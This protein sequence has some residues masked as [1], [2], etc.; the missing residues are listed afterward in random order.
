MASG[1]VNHVCRSCHALLTQANDHMHKLKFKTVPEIQKLVADGNVEGL[2]SISQTYLINAFHK[3]RFNM[4]NRRGIHGACPTDMLHSL[5]LGIFK[6]LRDIFFNQ[7]GKTSSI[8]KDVNGLAKVFCRLL[9]RQSDRS[10]PKCSFSQGIQAGRLMGREYRG[11]LLIMLC[12]L[13]STS[14]R[15]IM[16]Q[17]RKKMLNDDVKVDDWIMLVETLLQW[18][19]YLCSDELLVRDVRRL[20]KKHRY[21]MYLMRRIAHRTEG[22]GLKIMKFHTVLHLF[23]D[24]MVNGCPLEFDTSANEGHHKVS[25]H[26]AR[27]T[28]KAAKT[29]NLQ[30][31]NRITEFRLIEY[32]LL[33]LEEDKVPWNYFAGCRE[34]AS[35]ATNVSTSMDEDSSGEVSMA[36]ST[37]SKKEVQVPDPEDE[38]QAPEADVPDDESLEV[39]TGDAQLEVFEDEDGTRCFE[40]RTRSKYKDRTRLNLDIIDFLYDL[41]VLLSD[42]LGGDPLP[43]FTHHRRGDHIFRA[44]PNYRG[45]GA[46]RDWVW[47]DWGRNYGQ[48]PC[49]IWC[50]VKLECLGNERKAPQHG[51]ITLNQNGVYAVVESSEMEPDDDEVGRSAIMLP[52]RKTIVLTPDGAVAKRHFYLADVN[53]FVEPCSVV[54]DIGGPPNRY[55]VVKPR[56]K[57]SIDFLS[58]VRDSHDLDEMDDLDEDDQ[59]IPDEKV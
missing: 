28:Q 11:V 33:E 53:A 24:I 44:H 21:I 18:E 3:L 38:A 52:I 35:P 25:K 13:R 5:Q 45:K 32:A 58:W 19:A 31:A 59:V 42:Q 26:G 29:F 46:W 14:G 10:I 1:N 41:Q 43:I 48:I 27:L 47:I 36:S 9:S 2:Q 40:I 57:W 55:F 39:H 22:M 6:Y 56:P 12:I 50:F 49:H 4:A 17:S 54:A 37:S 51:G 16:G 7:L 8:S 34:E 15:Q 30:T 23:D 20:E